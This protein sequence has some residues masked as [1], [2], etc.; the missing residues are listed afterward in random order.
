MPDEKIKKTANEIWKLIEDPDAFMASI[1]NVDVDLKV[2]RLL[3]A[4]LGGSLS[5]GTRFDSRRDAAVAVL[6][7]R[8]SADQIKALNK[9]NSST[10][11][12]AKV[13]IGVGVIAALAAIIQ[14]LIVLCIR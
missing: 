6:Q 5:I 3:I 14:I 13:G 1:E 10:G 2:V 11:F 8:L 7:S 9:L 12:L 4:R